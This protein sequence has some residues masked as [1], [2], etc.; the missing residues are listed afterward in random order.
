MSPHN[1][2][3]LLDTKM[4]FMISCIWFIRFSGAS[5]MIYDIWYLIFYFA[6]AS[7]LHQ[8]FRNC[9]MLMTNL[10]LVGKQLLHYILRKKSYII[11]QKSGTM[12]GFLKWL[13]I[14]V[15]NGMI[16][17]NALN[18]LWYVINHIWLIAYGTLALR[19]FCI[20]T[21][22]SD[23]CQSVCYFVISFRIGSRNLSDFL[24]LFWVPY[25]LKING[26]RFFINIKKW[27]ILAQIMLKMAQNKVFWTSM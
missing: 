25:S 16:F 17:K 20:G 26:G 27:S 23:W 3:S 4:H 6:K 8:T 24:D 9:T 11:N 19:N 12:S 14:M 7:L 1:S 2:A 18:N 22:I 13:I 10:W 15:K 21:P 5:K